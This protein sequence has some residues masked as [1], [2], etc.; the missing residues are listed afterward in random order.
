MYTAARGPVVAF[1][2]PFR[3]RHHRLIDPRADLGPCWSNL[4]PR[5]PKSVLGVSTTMTNRP[6][7]G[8]VVRSTHRPGG[9]CCQGALSECPRSQGGVRASSSVHH[10]PGDIRV[11]DAIPATTRPRCILVYITSNNVMYTIDGEDVQRQGR[12]NDHQTTCSRGGCTSVTVVRVSRG[13]PCLWGWVLSVTP[14]V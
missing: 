9:R 11:H 10:L 12:I 1:V 8:Q 2:L 6:A 13:H 14:G 4:G 5:D 3:Y 7:F